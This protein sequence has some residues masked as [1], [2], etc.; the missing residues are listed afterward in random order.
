MGSQHFQDASSIKRNSIVA[1]VQEPTQNS[2]G[3]WTIF[4]P[5]SPEVEVEHIA[6]EVTQEQ[7]IVTIDE[8]S[9]TEEPKPA[10][11][12]APIHAP[13]LQKTSGSAMEEHKI[14]EP[15]PHHRWTK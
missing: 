12:F 11:V 10:A 14:S 3:V 4:S 7:E 13:H 9:T 5:E 2:L 15:K 6:E 1:K 8:A